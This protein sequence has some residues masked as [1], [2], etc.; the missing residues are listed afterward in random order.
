MSKPTFSKPSALLKA[1]SKEGLLQNTTLEKNTLETNTMETTSF[2]ENTT[3]IATLEVETNTMETTSFPP[4]FYE[5]Q[6]QGGEGEGEQ[7]QEEQGEQGEGQEEQPD[8]HLV[9]LLVTEGL[10]TPLDA[11]TLVYRAGEKTALSRNIPGNFCKVGCPLLYALCDTL[12]R[13]AIDRDTFLTILKAAGVGDDKDVQ[14]TRYAKYH[15]PVYKK[16]LNHFHKELSPKKPKKSASN[17]SSSSRSK[18]SKKRVARNDASTSMNDDDQQLVELQSKLDNTIK[19]VSQCVAGILNP[20]ELND[21]VQKV[22]LGHYQGEEQEQEEQYLG[23][24]ED[25]LYDYPMQEE[26]VMEADEEEEEQV[27]EKEAEAENEVLE[28]EDMVD[29]SLFVSDAEGRAYD[30]HTLTKQEPM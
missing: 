6:E 29:V 2:M 28:E 21:Q 30:V 16:L 15:E 22:V 10:V 1:L 5:E 14:Q 25:M 26:P 24:D 9:D 13:K 8:L 7:G 4:S 18:R 17:S 3:S 20:M 11:D 19:L 27:L 12:D 23:D